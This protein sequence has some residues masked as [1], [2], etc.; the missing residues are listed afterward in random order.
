M[1]V[2]LLVIVS[3][4]ERD[5]CVPVLCTHRPSL[6]KMGLRTNEF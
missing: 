1:N 4:V 3:S 2:E 5:E 6:S